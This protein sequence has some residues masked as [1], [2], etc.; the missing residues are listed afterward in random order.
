MA[1][2]L[3][4]PHYDV[5]KQ[6]LIEPFSYMEMETSVSNPRTDLSIWVRASD[7]A[8]M[9]GNNPV[10]S[11]D[12]VTSSSTSTDNALARFDGATGK[13]VQTSGIILGDDNILVLP[14]GTAVIKLS[15][16]PIVSVNNV[17]CRYGINAGLAM[18]NVAANKNTVLGNEAGQSLTTGASNTFVGYQTGNNQVTTN[19]N[20]AVGHQALYTP[21]ASGF[22]T[23]NVIMGYQTAYAGAEYSV[24]LGNEAGK[25]A[26]HRGSVLIGTDVLKSHTTQCTQNVIIGDSAMYLANGPNMFGNVLVGNSVVQRPTACVGSVVIGELIFGQHT[27]NVSY[28]TIVGYRSFATIASGVTNRNTCFGTEICYSTTSALNDNT[29]MGHQALRTAVNVGDKNV[30]IGANA[31]SA[32]TTGTNITKNIWIATPGV[33]NESNTVRIGNDT[34]HT[35]C[36]LAGTYAATETDSNFKIAKIGTNG[37]LVGGDLYSSLLTPIVTTV[38]FTFIPNTAD[39]NVSVT[40]TFTKVG[41]LITMYVPPVE[42][43]TIVTPVNFY[44][45]GTSAIPAGYVPALSSSVTVPIFTRIDGGYDADILGKASVVY[46]AIGLSKI[47]IEKEAPPGTGTFNAD[48]AGW[49]GF[50]INYYT[51]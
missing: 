26:I 24:I 33:A 31:G 25:A 3:H 36:F 50:V 51:D 46:G 17:N 20:T 10:M 29:I 18:T 40:V 13:I 38:T 34:D 27:G 23:K 19:L 35:R 30:V 41:R 7:G 4:V 15:T 9:L 43:P 8:L 14:A 11:T 12:T 16:T 47:K 22:G 49:D 42:L 28:N 37:Q 1:S 5:E 21:S 44:A 45:T 2:V 6:A 48:K 32:H 39:V